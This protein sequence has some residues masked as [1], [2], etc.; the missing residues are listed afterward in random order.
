M[1]E[2]KS[3]LLPRE[4]PTKVCASSLRDNVIKWS[5]VTQFFPAFLQCV[6]KM[7]PKMSRATLTRVTDL[8]LLWLY[9]GTYA[10]G[11]T[12]KIEQIFISNGV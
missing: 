10:R 11:I 5:R 3:S 8:G 2:L 1:R 7:A 4:K 6:P 9:F 12:E